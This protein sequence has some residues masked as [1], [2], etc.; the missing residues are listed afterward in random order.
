MIAF[1]FLISVFNRE[2]PQIYQLLGIIFIL[3]LVNM[4][5]VIFT[6]DR[7]E[8]DPRF[9]KDPCTIAYAFLLSYSF[10][11]YFIC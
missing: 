4:G 5:L 3:Y 8:I 11:N 2:S 9:E 10:V 7:Q 6:F 1:L